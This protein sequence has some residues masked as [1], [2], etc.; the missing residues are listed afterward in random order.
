MAPN[1]HNRNCRTERDSVMSAIMQMWPR[2]Y[3]YHCW[4]S[5]PGLISVILSDGQ[6]WNQEYSLSCW[7]IRDSLTPRCVIEECSCVICIHPTYENDTSLEQKK[8]H[9]AR[10]THL[11]TFYWELQRQTVSHYSTFCSLPGENWETSIL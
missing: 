8:K 7:Q 5:E 4:S 11:A 1:A 9:Y 6:G 10:M 3:S 2:E